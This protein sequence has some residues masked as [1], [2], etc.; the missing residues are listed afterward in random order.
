MRRWDDTEQ[1]GGDQALLRA[2]DVAKIYEKG[3]QVGVK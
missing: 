3:L 2:E 1:V